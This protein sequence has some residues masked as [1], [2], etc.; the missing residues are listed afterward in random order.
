[1]SLAP[2][3]VDLTGTAL[4]SEAARTRLQPNIFQIAAGRDEA[5]ILLAAQSLGPSR[6]TEEA[7]AFFQDIILDQFERLLAQENEDPQ[8]DS[9][10]NRFIKG[11]EQ[12]LNASGFTTVACRCE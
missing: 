6:P 10:A 3:R 4:D 2:V 1:M 12:A 9:P 5:V 8:Q 11:V 7:V